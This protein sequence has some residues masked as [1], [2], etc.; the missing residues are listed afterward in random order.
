VSLRPS[1]SRTLSLA[2]AIA[3]VMIGYAV[4]VATQFIVFP[5]FGIRTSIG[6]DLQVGGVFT[7]V[8]VVRSYGLRRLFETFRVLKAKREAAAPFGAAADRRSEVD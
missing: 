6:Q 7:A 5:L 3:N 2:E 8:S 4:A 1:Q